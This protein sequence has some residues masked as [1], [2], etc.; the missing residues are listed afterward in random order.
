MLDDT[1][2]QPSQ[3]TKSLGAGLNIEETEETLQA[4]LGGNASESRW[5]C[6]L[7]VTSF[8]TR[9]QYREHN[10]LHRYTATSASDRWPKKPEPNQYGTWKCSECPAEFRTKKLKLEHEAEHSN[11]VLNE[12][13]VLIDDDH[14]DDDFILP[15]IT[16]VNVDI[17]R[18]EHKLGEYQDPDMDLGLY[19][20]E[21]HSQISSL[22]PLEVNIAS[23]SLLMPMNV[24]TYN[25]YEKYSNHIDS[26]WQCRLCTEKFRTRDLLREHNHLY[27]ASKPP[28][29]KKIIKMEKIKNVIPAMNVQ[30][31]AM[32]DD[33]VYP[34]PKSRWQCETCLLF[35]DTREL[36]RIHRR[37]YLTKKNNTTGADE[38][39]G[40][41]ESQVNWESKKKK[42]IEQKIWID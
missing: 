34:N 31:Q 40:K 5:K 10:K 23:N 22:D 16:E 7:C 35:F 42:K 17:D 20:I 6:N 4:M 11:V 19:L 29:A 9:I 14:S 36:L 3:Y 39:D 27:M 21:K 24:V 26:K 38:L 41:K 8:D 25:S 33:V 32:L 30:V 37:T 13:T 18:H 12:P 28:K 2:E 15:N 1:R